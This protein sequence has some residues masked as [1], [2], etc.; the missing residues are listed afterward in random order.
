MY[1]KISLL[2][3]DASLPYSVIE[4]S[5]FARGIWA[6]FG[7]SF[8]VGVVIWKDLIVG[9]KKIQIIN[10]IINKIKIQ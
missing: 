2:G 4:G 1:S 3:K 6:G 5:E 9:K 7:G 8:S 10:K